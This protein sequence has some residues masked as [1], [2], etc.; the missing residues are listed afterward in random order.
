MLLAS[1]VIPTDALS[2]KLFYLDSQLV[3]MTI[4]I[5]I[6]KLALNKIL[7]IRM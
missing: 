7:Y 3:P 4:N 2:D 6:N 5:Y 1:T